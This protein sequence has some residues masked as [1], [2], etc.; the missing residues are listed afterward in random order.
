MVP[1][2]SRQMAQCVRGI[3]Q[4]IVYFVDFASFDLC[5]F[6]SNSLEGVNE[7]VDLELVLGL[8]WLDHEATYDGPAHSGSMEAEV[9]KALGDVL[10]C[11]S[12]SFLETTAI[13][14]ELVSDAIII[15]SKH[16]FKVV[17]KP[18]HDVVGIQDSNLG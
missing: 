14:D 7:A 13:K 6:F 1:L 12:C 8:C 15:A 2:I 10:L 11:D 18:M 4:N 16:D 17:L 3:L 9:H 5:D